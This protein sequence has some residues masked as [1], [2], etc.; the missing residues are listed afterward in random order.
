ME[1]VRD[2]A[3]HQS[4]QAFETLVSRHV[5]LVYSA[6]LR[7]V[8]DP[9][10]AEEITQAVFIILARKSGSLTAKTI[11]SGWLYRTAC[12]TAKDALRGQRRR[13]HYE[14]EAYMQ[15]TLQEAQADPAWQELSPLLDEAMMHLG[16]GDRDALVLRFFEKK[17]L[18]EI[19]AA[20]G[21]SEDAAKKRV[22]RALEKLRKYFLKRGVTS[23]AATIASA[24]SANSVQAAPVGLAKTISA[25]ALAKGAATSTSTLTLVK[26]AT[27]LM[28]WTKVKSMI[29][30]GVA[31][32]LVV[33]TTSVT[34]ETV[35]HNATSR[36]V[37]KCFQ[38]LTTRALDAAPPVLVLRP[39]RYAAMGDLAI[40][41]S[42]F[43]PNGRIMLRGA[44]FTEVLSTAYLIA[45]QQLVL[46]PNPP[47]GRFDV[48][49]TLK[50]NPRQALQAEIKKQFGLSAGLETRDTDVYVLKAGQTA[51][52]G[53]KISHRP[54]PNIQMEKGHLRLFG[55][56]MT[57]SSQ[58]DLVHTLA[59]VFDRPVID[60]TGLTDAYDIDLTW[61]RNVSRDAFLEE[62]R[63][64]L[65]NELGLELVPN[66]MPV[67]M[68][69]VERKQ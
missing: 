50:Q 24:I 13:Q 12:Y 27:K 32:I 68:L 43:G 5:S 49:L 6:A 44:T 61:G 57:D 47:S 3:A 55:Y 29:V 26:G 48:L 37:E 59:S 35:K 23:A 66:N 21:M 39:S 10:L 33:G 63:T 22:S 45:P 64:K 41:G 65:Y 7:Q 4:E 9:H 16:Q 53:L 11:L 17:N 19:G 52:P 62:F 2:Y 36:A 38:S 8:H 42:N 40:G 1:L 54:G 69:V 51:A 60:E 30:T 58:Y 28:A 46:P 20:S 31:A 25:A 67:E 14:Q 56:K 15:S 18:R 34:V